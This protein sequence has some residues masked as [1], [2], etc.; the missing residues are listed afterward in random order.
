MKKHPALLLVLFLSTLC[1]H[2]FAQEAPLAEIEFRTLAAADLPLQEVYYDVS[3]KAVPVAILTS[4]KSHPYR[5]KKASSLEFYVL[6]GTEKK[7]KRVIARAVLPEKKQ[8]LL[9]VFAPQPAG[10]AMS[11][12][13]QVL[14]DSWEAH[15]AGMVRTL[16]YTGEVLACKIA[17]DTFSLSAGA[18]R[19]VKIPA[20]WAYLPVQV[21][22]QTAGGA[23]DLAYSSTDQLLPKIR[24]CIVLRQ[25][26]G[27]SVPHHSSVVGV[28]LLD[29]PPPK[30][31]A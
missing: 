14:D 24:A 1:P 10:Q 22:R 8:K 31:K 6:A 26:G 7:E 16:N 12:G 25:A 17:E 30:P 2:V 27:S 29:F 3:G 9:L 15:P 28:T 23:W 5:V 11:C 18:E 20:S 19:L 21:A 13:V 4:V